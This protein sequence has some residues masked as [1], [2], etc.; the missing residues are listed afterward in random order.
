VYHHGLFVTSVIGFDFHPY[1]FGPPGDSS[2][3][4]ATAPSLKPLIK[5]K[6]KRKK[7]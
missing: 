5:K 1:W 7:K 6:K 2:P 4:A 3:T